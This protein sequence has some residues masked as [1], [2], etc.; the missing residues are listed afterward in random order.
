MCETLNHQSQLGLIDKSTKILFPWMTIEIIPSV[1]IVI[2]FLKRWT[3]C[4][5]P[6]TMFEILYESI[7]RTLANP[8]NT[9]YSSKVSR[10]MPE[11]KA[12]FQIFSLKHKAIFSMRS[13]V[14]YWRTS[15]SY[16]SER[17]HQIFSHKL[18]DHREFLVGKLEAAHRTTRE[19]VSPRVEQYP[20]VFLHKTCKR[21]VFLSIYIMLFIQ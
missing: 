13:H 8:F 10:E 19:R 4:C 1:S 6:H 12:L 18:L 11:A 21:R 9:I 20:K 17:S 3:W 14:H 2:K 7:Q 16:Q 5:V 15:E